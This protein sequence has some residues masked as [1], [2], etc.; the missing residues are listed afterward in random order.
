VDHPNQLL[1]GLVTRVRLAGEN[2]QHRTLEVI[3]QARQALGIGE[4]QCGPFVGGETAGKTDGEDVGFVRAQQTGHAVDERLA[5]TIA[6]RLQYHAAAHV[7]EQ[8]RFQ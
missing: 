8:F 1:T 2:E 7:G 3:Q 6:P 5:A 4:Q